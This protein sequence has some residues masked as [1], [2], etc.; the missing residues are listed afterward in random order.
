MKAVYRHDPA[1]F[2][3]YAQRVWD[4]DLA[5]ENPE[6]I[7]L[8]GIRRL[9]AFFTSLGLPVRLGALQIDDR[10]FAQMAERVTRYGPVGHFKALSAQDVEEIYRLAL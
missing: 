6:R 2:V 10:D 9:E 1:R 3:Q 7:I 5:Q 8:E 4:V